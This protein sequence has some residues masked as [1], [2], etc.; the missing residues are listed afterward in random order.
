[1]DKY[2]PTWQVWFNKASK[3]LRV[4][5]LLLEQKDKDFYENAV[6]HSQQ[7][8]EKAIKGYLAKSKIRF[9][10]THDIKSLIDIV[11]SIDQKLAHDIRPS[12]VLTKYAVAIRY[13]EEAED[14][15]PIM[16]DYKLASDSIKIASWVFAELKALVI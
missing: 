5:E 8:V 9:T 12:E 11:D 4:A 13:P 10:K 1:L 3:D 6:F 2:I 14:H 15:E 7:C 16:I